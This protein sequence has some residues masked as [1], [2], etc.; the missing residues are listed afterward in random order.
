MAKDPD[1]PSTLYSDDFSTNG[2][3]TTDSDGKANVFLV[4]GD[5]AATQQGAT[6]T[7]T[8]DS[9]TETETFY[10]SIGTATSKS[11]S[12]T[13]VAGTDGQSTNDYGGLEKPL[14][15]VVRDQ[16]GRRLI[17]TE[18]RFVVLNAGTIDYDSDDPGKDQTSEQTQ[19]SRVQEVVTDASGEAS[20]RYTAP[21]TGGRQTVRASIDNGLK[22]VVFTINGPADSVAVVALQEPLILAFPAQGLHALLR[23]AHSKTRRHRP[24]SLSIYPSQALGRHFQRKVEQPPSPARSRSQPPQQAR[25]PSMPQRL[26]TSIRQIP[27]RYCRRYR[28]VG[29]RDNLVSPTSLSGASGAVVQPGCQCWHC[30]CRCRRR[31]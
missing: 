4:L 23:C 27:R 2:N 5:T 13:R 7:F 11:S 3:V 15:V 21:D 26:E 10:A 19:D 6:A 14:T 9:S 8:V 17:D 24:A 28:R 22:S 18:V 31:S 29:Y 25:I 16:G 12:I 20:V 30:D 1:F